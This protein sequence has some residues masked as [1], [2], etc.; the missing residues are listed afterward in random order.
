MKLS[1]VMIARNEAENVAPCFES[2]WDYCDQVVLCDTGSTDA[3]IAEA[4]R[5]ARS[6][7]EPDKLVIARHRWRND[8]AAARNAAHRRATGSVH[9]YLDLDERL[10][11]GEHLRD[12]AQRLADDPTLDVISALWSGPINPEQWQ[13]RLFRPPVTWE[14]RTWETP[15]ENGTMA[16]SDDIRIH[17]TRETPRGRRDLEIAERWAADEPDNWRP[18]RALASEA[19]DLELWDVVLDAGSGLLMSD[20]PAEIRSFLAVRCARAHRELGDREQAEQMACAAI[21]VLDGERFDWSGSACSAHLMLAAWALE[22]RKPGD[23][24]ES[25]GNALRSAPTDELRNEAAAA[26]RLAQR[27]LMNETVT[28]MVNRLSPRDLMTMANDVFGGVRA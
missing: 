6:K 17:H 16:M 14:G 28:R 19:T 15:L 8:F 25:A 12:E 18:F 2:F 1:M 13:P 24:L 26:M 20:T 11:G 3:T 22:D 27:G 23:A 7:G 21:N 9:T 5:F 4:R 10:V